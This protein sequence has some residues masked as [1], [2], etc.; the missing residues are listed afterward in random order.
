[1]C[2]EYDQDW[3]MEVIRIKNLKRERAPGFACSEQRNC[4]DWEQV[5]NT[6]AKMDAKGMVI[7]LLV[8]WRNK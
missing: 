7:S 4:H 5:L 3:R 1:M 6:N 8:N 2:K